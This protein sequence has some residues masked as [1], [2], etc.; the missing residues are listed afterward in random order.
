ML[1]PEVF[2]NAVGKGA[3]KL[4]KGLRREFFR[5]EFDKQILHFFHPPP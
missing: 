4:Q 5:L 3:R 1:L 2:G